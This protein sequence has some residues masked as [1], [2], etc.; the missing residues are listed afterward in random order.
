MIPTHPRRGKGV[1]EDNNAGQVKFNIQ[2]KNHYTFCLFEGNM[3]LR[4]CR[5][6]EHL[7]LKVSR[8]GWVVR[9]VANSRIV[10]LLGYKL[11]III[12]CNVQS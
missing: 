4:K 12:T 10:P 5:T 2:N 11:Y 3:L 1:H 6:S 7:M 9:P 8:G